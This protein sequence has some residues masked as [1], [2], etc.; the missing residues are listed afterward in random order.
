MFVLLNLLNLLA[1]ILTIA[2]AITGLLSRESV[3]LDTH[4]GFGLLAVFTALLTLSIAPVFLITAGR[5]IR[6]NIFGDKTIRANHETSRA[7]KMRIFPLILATMLVYMLI[8]AGGALVLAGKSRALWHLLSAI[9]ATILITL[10]LKKG[11]AALRLNRKIM[12]DTIRRR[13]NF[14]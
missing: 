2:A 3:D 4:I 6:D 1:L 9:A 7:I 8:P 14:M 5:L 13:K 11:F 12:L 10:Y